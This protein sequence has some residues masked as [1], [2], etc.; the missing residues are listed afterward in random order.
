MKLRN[1][2]LL[3]LVLAATVSCDRSQD[4]AK[5]GSAPVTQGGSTDP[6]NK[7]EAAADTLAKPLFWQLEK[8]GKT[9]YLLGTIH[10]GVDPKRLPPIVYEKLDAAKSF[11]METDLAKASSLDLTR[12]DGSTLKDELGPE[13]WKKL[14]EALGQQEAMGVNKLKPMIAATLLS[15]RGLPRTTAM[16]GA[17]EARAQNKH[18]QIV[19]L[20]P[21][22]VQ[23]AAL[24]KWMNVRA[25][26]DMLDDVP[27]TDQRMKELFAAYVAGD[28]TK[29]IEIVDGERS[30]W[31]AK[32]R[33]ESEYDEQM[34]DMLYKRN[35][36]WIAPI[37]KLHA[38]GGGFIA[39]GAA[40]AVGPRSVNELLEQRGFKI[41][42]ITP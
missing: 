14:V 40:H 32:G 38:D 2:S 16:D 29:M 13:Y 10:I 12:K 37:E 26:K 23:A 28:G 1:A 41:T 24:E 4:G 20:E 31:K 11:A 42:R 34:D 6:W 21:F 19:F 15:I 8:D 9:S 5:P 25:L 7:P 39:V 3:A 36:S 35:A 22:E 33:P 18:K 27:G 17:L 30:R